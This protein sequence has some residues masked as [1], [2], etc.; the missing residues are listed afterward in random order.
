MRLQLVAASRANSKTAQIG[1]ELELKLAQDLKVGAD[2]VIPKGTP[3]EALITQADP[4]DT[5]ELPGT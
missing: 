1:D 2:V 3:L 5:W 4:P